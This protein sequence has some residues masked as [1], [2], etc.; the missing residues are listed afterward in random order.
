MSFFPSPS[1]IAFVYS[2]P[3][4]L[5]IFGLLPSLHFPLP[6]SLAL[7]Y[8]LPTFLSIFGILPSLHLRLLSPYLPLLLWST[9]SLPFLSIFGLLP[10]LYFRC[11]FYSSFTFFFFFRFHV[12]LLF[13][14][15]RFSSFFVFLFFIIIS[16]PHA[17]YLIVTFIPLEAQKSNVI[18]YLQ[19]IH[20]CINVFCF[21]YCRT[22]IYHY[23]PSEFSQE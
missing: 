11:S 20:I 6:S 2:L 3:I 22:R 19:I 16:P 1:S 23:H 14:F 5:F 18:L 12:F 9:V 13:S 15:S 10:S 7:V 8:L 17:P 21:I 4:F